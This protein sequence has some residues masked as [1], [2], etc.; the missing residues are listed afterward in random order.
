MPSSWRQ[1]LEKYKWLIGIYIGFYLIFLGILSYGIYLCTDSSN[2]DWTCPGSTCSS[3]GTSTASSATKAWGPCGKGHSE[4][5]QSAVVSHEIQLLSSR[6]PTLRPT[7]TPSQL[8]SSPSRSPTI[9]YAATFSTDSTCEAQC[10]NLDG[11]VCALRDYSCST[12]EYIDSYYCGEAKRQC[13]DPTALGLIISTATVLG[14]M[15]IGLLIN[16]CIHVVHQYCR[17]E[18]PQ[19]NFIPSFEFNPVTG[20]INRIN[21]LGDFTAVAYSDPEADDVTV[22]S[23]TSIPNKVSF[24]T[25]TDDLPIVELLKKKKRP[26]NHS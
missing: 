20:N 21:S 8:P 22:A 5:S 24:V 26:K 13:S 15:T 16:L 10:G 9:S 3:D 7:R 25:T 11:V 6:T 2:L 14:I 23:D 4:S 17:R 1:I 19:R 12:G 18:D